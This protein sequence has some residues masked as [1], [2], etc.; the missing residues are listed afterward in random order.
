M[1]NAMTP[2]QTYRGGCKA[3]VES[4]THNL[5]H[6]LTIR[7][8]EQ[9]YLGLKESKRI[10]TYLIYHGSRISFELFSVIITSSII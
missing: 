10:I 5:A 2:Y 6:R 1:K 8:V 7:A 4:V 3:L 9:H